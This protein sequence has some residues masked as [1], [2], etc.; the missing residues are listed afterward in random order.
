M[1]ESDSFLRN[2]KRIIKIIQNIKAMPIGDI[3]PLGSQ[4]DLLGVMMCWIFAIIIGC[5]T[6]ANRRVSILYKYQKADTVKLIKKTL[7]LLDIKEMEPEWKKKKF[8]QS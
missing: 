6:F 1:L 7:V 3:A 8:I 5:H 4:S 2:E